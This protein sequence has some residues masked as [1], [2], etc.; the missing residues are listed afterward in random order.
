[1]SELSH[2][3]LDA[4]NTP[5]PPANETTPSAPAPVTVDASA[6]PKAAPS[7]SLLDEVLAASTEERSWLAAFLDEPDPWA[8]IKVWLTHCGGKEPS[9]LSQVAFGAMLDTDIAH[10]DQMLT[11]QANAI[12]HHKTFQ[13]LESSWRGL[14]YTVNQASQD[15]DGLTKVRVLDVSWRELERDAERAIEF[16]QTQLWRKVY[17]EEYDMPGGTPYGVLVGDYEVCHRQSKD[18]PHDD[19][20]IIRSIAQTA[21]S[22]FVPFITSAHPSLLGLSDFGQLERHIDMDRVFLQPE[23]A[24]WNALRREEDMKFIGLTAPRTLMRLPRDAGYTN[25][26]APC[27][28]ACRRALPRISNEPTPCPACGKTI[29]KE[30]SASLPYQA[31]GFRYEEA[32]ESKGENGYLWGNSAYAFAGI[33]IRAF[34]ESRWL[35][36]IRGFDRNEETA[37]VVAD[38]PSQSFGHDRLGVAMKMA[39]DVAIDDSQEKAMSEHGLIPLSHAHDTDWHV[40]YSNNSLH[41][42]RVYDDDATTLNARISSMLQYTFCTA[43]FAH[44]LKVQMRQ[45]IGSQSEAYEMQNRLIN[46][47]NSYVTQDSQASADIKARYPLREAEIEVS[48]TPGKPGMYHCEMKLWPHYQ[49]DEVSVSVRMI[50][51][52]SD[53]RN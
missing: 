27:C 48:E 24:S 4:S 34:A 9:R 23:Y 35:A 29:A 8:A 11:D 15:T 17:D 49:L 2:E 40:F 13:K 26:D 42:A 16:D 28:P 46:W 45:R 50:T 47:I 43:R 31:M 12:L 6:E 22:A 20:N 21:A 44:Y 10:L 19:V 38:L 25:T 7:R 39:T 3:T 32:S 14:A 37:G 33:L 36:D 41:K 30:D 51:A 52:V 1:M 53:R 5:G 18:H